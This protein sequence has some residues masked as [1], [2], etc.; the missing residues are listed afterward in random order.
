[1]DSFISYRK[2]ISDFEKAIKEGIDQYIAELNEKVEILDF[3]ISH[4]DDGR[5]KSFYCNAV[6]LLKLPEL[7][8]I[9][10]EINKEIDKQDINL[11]DKITLIICRFEAAANKENLELKLRK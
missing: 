3:L 1:M 8:V 9:V 4:Y 11:K 10:D 2:V 6:N 5:R 7:Q